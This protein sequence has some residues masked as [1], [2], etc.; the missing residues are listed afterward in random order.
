MQDPTT[1]VRRKPKGDRPKKAG[2]GGLPEFS[3]PNYEDV[4]KNNLWQIGAD[5]GELDY[6]K[7]LKLRQNLAGT[8]YERFV[9]PASD[10]KLA[11]GQELA[12]LNAMNNA[13]DERSKVAL[14]LLFAR[15]NTRSV[16]QVAQELAHLKLQKQSIDEIDALVTG[17]IAGDNGF[18]AKLVNGRN[19][20]AQ[21]REQFAR[22]PRRE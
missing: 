6:L 13:Q 19:A 22:P 3:A 16:W 20:A 21:Q 18:Y 17:G 9:P 12:V 15:F 1:R 2:M 8:G 10:R 11:V 7:R 5:S 14:E 4:E